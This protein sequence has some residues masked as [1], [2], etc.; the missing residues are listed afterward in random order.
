MLN[1]LRT[2][3]SPARKKT[4]IQARD[5]NRL[6][7][8]P[9]QANHLPKSLRLITP[10][11]PSWAGESRDGGRRPPWADEAMRS[12]LSAPLNSAPKDPSQ[13]HRLQHIPRKLPRLVPPFFA[14]LRRSASDEEHE[15]TKGMLHQSLR[16][17][18]V[19]PPQ[20]GKFP[21]SNFQISSNIQLPKTKLR[22]SKRLLACP[23]ETLTPFP[24]DLRK[25][26]VGT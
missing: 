6:V 26:H 5:C 15:A 1:D 13:H 21:R 20:G 3:V 9:T 22:T 17:V 11:S 4:K 2:Q 19:K 12:R 14:K 25:K 8:T 24:F 16:A 10:P 7:K 23:R 18:L